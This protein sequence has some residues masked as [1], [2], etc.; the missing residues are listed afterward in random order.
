M[1]LAEVQAKLETT[2]FEPFTGSLADFDNFLSRDIAQ[3]KVLVKS[4]RVQVE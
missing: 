2:G 4:G 1:A 3:L